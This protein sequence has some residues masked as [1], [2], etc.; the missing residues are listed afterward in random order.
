MPTY[1]LRTKDEDGHLTLELTDHI[2]RFIGVKTLLYDTDYTLTVS[3][4]PEMAGW[5]RT[6]GGI[7]TTVPLFTRDGTAY[8]AKSG[9]THKI[10]ATGTGLGNASITASKWYSS[11][12]AFG[13]TYNPTGGS[14]SSFD[15]RSDTNLLLFMYK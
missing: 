10:T 11:K 5:D 1:G 3:N 9:T 7:W 8:S 2:T 15:I 13:G 12:E 4:F 14:N 6:D